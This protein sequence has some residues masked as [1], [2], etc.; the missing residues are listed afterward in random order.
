[1]VAE[2]VVAEHEAILVAAET[3][4]LA[5]GTE[6]LAASQV[7]DC[8]QVAAFAER[9]IGCFSGGNAHC[10]ALATGEYDHAGACLCQQPQNCLT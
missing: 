7:A 1:M 5:V 3:A 2:I 6:C 10:D 4:V 8:K 9:Y